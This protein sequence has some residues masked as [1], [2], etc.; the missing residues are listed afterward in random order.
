MNIELTFT[1][2]TVHWKKCEKLLAFV[3]QGPIPNISNL[4]YHIVQTWFICGIC[5]FVLLSCCVFR[6][7]GQL[8]FTPHTAKEC[9]TSRFCLIVFY[10]KDDG[11]NVDILC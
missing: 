4:L 7:Y 3:S 5:H 6:N 11:R 2:N 8:I 9:K 10:N 1:R